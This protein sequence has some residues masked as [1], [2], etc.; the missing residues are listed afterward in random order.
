MEMKLYGIKYEDGDKEEINEAELSKIIVRRDNGIIAMTT[1][2]PTQVELEEWENSLDFKEIASPGTIEVLSDELYSSLDQAFLTSYI[3]KRHADHKQ[4]ERTKSRRRLQ[5]PPPKSSAKRI[6]AAD[7]ESP[8]RAQ[9]RTS[10]SASSFFNRATGKLTENVGEFFRFMHERQSIWVRRKNSQYL[11]WTKADGGGDDKVLSYD[12]TLR[13]YHFCNIYRELD[14]GTAFFHAHVLKLREAKKE[15]SDQE[16]LETVLWA[17]YVYRQVNR[18][19]TFT[20]I[21]IPSMDQ[22]SDFKVKAEKYGETAS[23]FTGAHQTTTFGAYLTGL[24]AMSRTDGLLLKQTANKLLAAT[25]VIECLVILESLRGI[26]EFMGWQLFC[27]LRE[28]GC[29]THCAGDDFC[30]LG[31]GAQSE[32]QDSCRG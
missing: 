3:R 25:T 26:A 13:T 10:G 14:R 27:D 20:E 6:R 29:L 22:V 12:E 9:P 31:P 8:K 30:R 18:V 21:G 28:C 23:F 4:S 19:E 15:W 11:T 17:T 5:S 1:T 7:K 24:R 16:W 32:F 2:K